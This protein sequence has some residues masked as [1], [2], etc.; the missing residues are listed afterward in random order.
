LASKQEEK[1]RYSKQLKEAIIY[2]LRRPMDEDEMIMARRVYWS[3]TPC[4]G[5]DGWCCGGELRCS[6]FPNG[7]CSGGKAVPGNSPSKPKSPR[8]ERKRIWRLDCLDIREE[9]PTWRYW[10]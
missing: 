9:I 5:D 6:S 7:R 2:H 3:H 10:W 4:R 8:R 1:K